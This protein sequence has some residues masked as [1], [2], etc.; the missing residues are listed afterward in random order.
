MR[1]PERG[2]S[3]LEQVARRTID[4]IVAGGALLVLAPLMVLIAVVIKLTSPGPVVFTQR[5]VG[6]G[7]E[8]F[9]FY[10]FRTMR[11]G[12]D[13]AAH[14]ELIAREYAE[15]IPRSAAAT[16]STVTTASPRSVQSCAGPVSTSYRN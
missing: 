13:D 9:W 2:T 8:P 12:T 5:R 14:R 10:K 11:M 4:I 15:K 3:T 1:R 7:R 16:S 6:F